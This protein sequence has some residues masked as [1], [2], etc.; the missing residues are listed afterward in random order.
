VRS[1]PTCL[2]PPKH[3]FRIKK[4]WLGFA[5]AGNRCPIFGIML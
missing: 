2:R 4:P 3:R 1:F 5:L